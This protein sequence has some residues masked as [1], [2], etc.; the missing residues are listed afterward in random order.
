MLIVRIKAMCKKAGIAKLDGG[1]KGATIQFHND[2]FASPMG[3]VDFIQNEKGTA[4]VKDNKIVVL[5][6]WKKDSDKIKGAYAI[7]RDLA[8][9]VIA[10]KK[11]KKI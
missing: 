9:K 11:R 6:D 1:P 7:A 4:K 2:K 3:L 8:E 5:R 10:E